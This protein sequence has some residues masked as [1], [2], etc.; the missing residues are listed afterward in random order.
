M[1]NNTDALILNTVY[2]TTGNVIDDVFRAPHIESGTD[3][4]DSVFYSYMN[5]QPEDGADYAPAD[6]GRYWHGYRI[7]I[8]PL[9]TVFSL[10]GIRALNMA[11]QTALV[12]FV[13]LALYRRGRRE[14]MVPFALMWFS[15]GP[16]TLF[17]SLQ[18]SST[19][20]VTMA[21]CLTI[22]LMYGK[23]SF[24]WLCF[25]FEAA[26]VL[27]AYFDF[28][29]YPAVCFAVPAILFFALD[30]KNAA[31]FK[32]RVRQLF[33][34]GLAWGVGY[35]GMWAGKWVL[36]TLLTSENALLSATQSIRTRTS[37]GQDEYSFTYAGTLM[38]NIVYFANKALAAVTAAAAAAA[39]VMRMMTRRTGARCNMPA[40][41]IVALCA[42][43]PFVWY[44]LT[45]NHSYIHAWF[46]FR[47]LSICLYGVMTVLYMLLFPPYEACV[48]KR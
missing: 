1:D 45:V 29:T 7:V 42:L 36:S 47:E 17:F 21:L 25:A 44:I 18:Y 14:M 40:V 24:S 30:A 26:G 46:T 48:N 33:F 38:K 8:A 41:G 2:Y 13:L 27:E 28:L 15:L 3:S 37:S 16:L 32:E 4:P 5:P 6:Y 34:M 12:F 11:A 43:T 31:G 22:A 10:S 20:Y 19:F 9:L 39:V 23:R 35:I